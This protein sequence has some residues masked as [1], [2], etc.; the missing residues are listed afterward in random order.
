M[1]GWG[2]PAW[3]AA[4]GWRVRMAIVCLTGMGSS[5]R[6][7]RMGERVRVEI[8]AELVRP[9]KAAAALEGLSLRAWAERELRGSW[10][11]FL[12]RSDEAIKIGYSA[13]PK[14]RVTTLRGKHGDLEVLALMRGGRDEERALHSRFAM[15]R[16]EGEWFTATPELLAFVAE[17]ATLTIDEADPG[18]VKLNVSV[19]AEL[20]KA[21]K[22]RAAA[23][24]ETLE[25]LVERGLRLTLPV[26]HPEAK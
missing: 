25:S 13:Q 19:P 2:G 5:G 16:L 8:P 15:S 11:Y 18:R 3:L 21:A 7:G 23:N 1:E 9:A 4:N 26:E 24:G 20:R 17:M 12:R 10:V 6:V 14:V 22:V